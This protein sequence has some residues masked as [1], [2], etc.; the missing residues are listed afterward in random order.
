MLPVSKDELM[1]DD[2]LPEGYGGE[3]AKPAKTAKADAKPKKARQSQDGR[4][5]GGS[6]SSGR[7]CGGGSCRQAGQA[8][9][10]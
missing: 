8:Q 5:R 10:G 2:E 3:E 4:R 6:R 7:R 1:A 9:G